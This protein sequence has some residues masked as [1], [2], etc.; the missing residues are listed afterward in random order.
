MKKQYIT[1]DGKVFSTED[2]ATAHEVHLATV[3]ANQE[4]LAAEK[5][6]RKDDIKADYIA[7]MKKVAQYNSDYGEPLSYS[8][9]ANNLY[10]PSA[11]IRDIFNAANLFRW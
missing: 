3:K 4:K 5:Q 9:K 6:G 1:D 7:L 10:S 11:L 2:E 8:E